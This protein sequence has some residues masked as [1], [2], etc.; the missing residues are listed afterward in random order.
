M[1]KPAKG[2]KLTPKQKLFVEEYVIDKNASRAARAAGYSPKTAHRTGQE[3]MQRPAIREA[4]EEKMGKEL[5]KVAMTAEDVLR[6]LATIANVPM[7]EKKYTPKDKL[8][9]LELFGKNMQLFTDKVIVSDNA[10]IP[11][12]GIEFTVGE[13]GTD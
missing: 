12:A 10:D 6:E 8:R 3:N 11:V 13:D 4:I 5:K 1:P 9:A 2:S 7:P